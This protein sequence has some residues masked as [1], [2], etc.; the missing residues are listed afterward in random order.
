MQFNVS[1]AR[2]QKGRRGMARP[3]GVVLA[4]GQARRM[5]GGDKALVRLAGRPLLAHV[6]DRIGPQVAVLAV[7][8]NGDGARFG[9]E[10][11]VLPDVVA[12]GMGPLAGILSAMEWAAAQGSA[13]VL[14]VAV[15]TPF[16][17]ADLVQTMVA[18]DAPVV[19]ARTDDGWQG[20]T[21]LWSV[22]LR[23]AL[24]AALAGGTRKVTDWALEAGAVEA[25]FAAST[26]PAFFNI[27]TPDDLARADAWLA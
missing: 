13:R 6:M 26:P 25:R 16:L 23:G 9:V 15:D 20:T 19:L 24:R 3:V 4:G 17:P 14:T 2:H 22:T 18:V 21:G 5:G 1:D 27:N 7:N 11:P 10:A 12:H 8:A